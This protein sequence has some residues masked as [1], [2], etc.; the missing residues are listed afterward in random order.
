[1]LVGVLP[2]ELTSAWPEM[3]KIA[4]DKMKSRISSQLLLILNFIDW[5]SVQ[6]VLFIC[7]QKWF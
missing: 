4:S 5:G 7:V 6:R 1:M 3:A 2:K